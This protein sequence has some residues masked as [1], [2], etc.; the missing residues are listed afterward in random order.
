MSYIGFFVKKM[1]DSLI[2]SF[3]VSNVS[4]SL[5]SLTK[6]EQMSKLL[7]F[8]SELLIRSFFR[9]KTSDSL[10]KPMSKLPALF[11]S[12]E[13]VKRCLFLMKHEEVEQRLI[14]RTHAQN[15]LYFYIC[16]IKNIKKTY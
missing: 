5:R 9:K 3:L 16:V 12:F 14:F 4:E 15:M 6:N 13:V 2:P 8:L 7:V 1:S 10:R 11:I